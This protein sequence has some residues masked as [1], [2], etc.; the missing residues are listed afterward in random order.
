MNLSNNNAI[1]HIILSAEGL[2]NPTHM[3]TD[4]GA[5]SN[6]IKRKAVKTS[7]KINKFECLKL[8]GINK[9]PVFTL[10]QITI[11]ILGYLTTINIIPN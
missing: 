5:R 7:V 3:M 2:K 9:H 1:P 4:T 8:R 10:G 11:N 6:L